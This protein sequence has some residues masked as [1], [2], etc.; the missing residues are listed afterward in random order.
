MTLLLVLR[1]RGSIRQILDKRDIAPD[2]QRL[3]LQHPEG[4]DPPMGAPPPCKHAT[5]DGPSPRCHQHG[6]AT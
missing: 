4:T 5:A 6:G 3:T 1:L 2:Q